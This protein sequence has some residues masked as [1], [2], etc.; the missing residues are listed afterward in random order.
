MKK[1]FL[2]IITLLIFAYSSTLLMAETTFGKPFSNGS[3]ACVSCHSISAAGFTTPAWAIDLSTAYND[4]GNDPETMK[5]FIKSSGIRAMDA[6]YANAT[7]SAAELDA[8]ISS[9]AEISSK[10]PV[11]LSSFGIYTAAFGVFI[12]FLIIVRVFFRK[13]IKLEENR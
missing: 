13:N 3:P 10:K 12:V 7:I 1:F 11:K 6:V 8:K 4:L 9:F 2:I 5:S